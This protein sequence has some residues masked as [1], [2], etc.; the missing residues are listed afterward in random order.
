MHG[1]VTLSPWNVPVPVILLSLLLLLVNA[2]AVYAGSFE[3]S[4]HY[5]TRRVPS[6]QYGVYDPSQ[7]PVPKKIDATA[8]GKNEQ[9]CCRAGG[10]PRWYAGLSGFVVFLQDVGIKL[11]SSS[12]ALPSNDDTYTT[13]FGFGFAAQIGY[14][15]TPDIRAE[16]ELAARFNDLDRLN[17]Q[18]P[19]LNQGQYSA[20]TSLAYMLNGY[21]DFHN[22][23]N[24]TPYLGAGAGVAFVKAP[25][26]YDGYGQFLSVYTPAYQFMAGVSYMI[27]TGGL[28]PFIVHAGYR[29]FSGIDPEQDFKNFPITGTYSNDSHNF[30]LGGKILF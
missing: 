8:R 17:G 5:E 27:D 1:Y 19:Q 16:F 24:F 11:E 23:S 21:Y 25:V 14:F 26:Q 6:Y 4:D 29:Y 12:F 3:N 7:Q 20:H 9:P 28:N 2:P 15:V 30:E 22:S 18:S 10:A 13:D